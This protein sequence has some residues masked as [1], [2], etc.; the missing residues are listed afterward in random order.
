MT[1]AWQST[2]AKQLLRVRWVMTVLFT[3][4]TAICIGTL[5]TIALVNDER[6]RDQALDIELDRQVAGLSRVVYYDGDGNLH[7]EPLDV[8]ALVSRTS[9]LHVWTRENGAWVSKYSR[10]VDNAKTQ[11]RSELA[12]VDQVRDLQYA[13]L[14]DGSSP[15][16]DRLRLAAAPV[17]NTTNQVAAIV[18][19]AGDPAPGEAA[20]REYVMW[21]FWGCLAMLVLAAAAGHLLSY[22]G[23]RPAVRA[24]EQEERFLA[25]AAHELRTPLATLRLIAESGANDPIRASASAAQ[26]VGLVDRMAHL[27]T[28]L[29]ARARVRNGTREMEWLPLRLDQLVEEVVGEQIDDGRTVDVDLHPTVVEGDP[30]LLSQALRNLVDNAVKHG[31][32]EDGRVRVEVRVSGGTVTV[33]D[34]G[35]GIDVADRDRVFDQWVTGSSTGTGIGLAIVR[36]VADL[37]RGSARVVDS[38]LGGTT[39]ELALPEVV[40]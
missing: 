8:D 9:L 39:I 10:E 5:A 4:T 17:W 12:L 36:W 38:P 24:L 21:T 29:L 37:H 30:V 1:T 26:V 31:T 7:L 22:I 3:A 34:R 18:V 33:S 40:G 35:P 13:V 28:G 14:G 11:E 20:H 19:V 27:V 23:T 25:E 6:S 16:G 2:T 32:Q 15:A